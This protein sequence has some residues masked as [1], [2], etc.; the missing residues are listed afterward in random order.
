MQIT[1]FGKITRAFGAFLISVTIAILLA[2]SPGTAQEGAEDASAEDIAAQELVERAKTTIVTLEPLLESLATLESQAQDL[3]AQTEAASEAEQ[4]ALQE[5]LE[6]LGAEIDLVRDQISIVVTGVSEQEY[7]NLEST[8]F[9]LRRELEAL[10]EPFVSG[11]KGATENARQ[12]ERTRRALAATGRRLADAELAVENTEAAIPQASND[13]VLTLLTQ[14]LELWKER[15]E[16]NRSQY[17]ALTQQL[18]DLSSERAS[19]R[20]NVDSA[21]SGFFRDRGLSILLGLSAFTGFLVACR[22]IRW[23]AL[24]IYGFT[25]RPT[26]FAARLSNL[27]FTGFTVLG[28]FVAMIIVFNLRNDWLLLGLAGLLTFALLWLAIRMLPN[29]LEQITVLLNLGAVQEDER[30]LFNGV[31][32]RVSKLSFYTD[33]VNPALDGGEFTLPVRELVGLHSRPAAENE[34]WFP[35]EKGD[36]VRL[37]DGHAGQVVAQTPEMVVLKLLGGA[38]VT[39]QTSD[40]LDQTPENLSHGFRVE[41]EFGISY[42][43]QAKAATE[44]PRLM[45]DGVEAR[46]KAFLRDESLRAVEVEL[47]RAGTSSIDYEVEVDVGGAAAPRFEE[48]ERELARILVEL[49]TEND[50]EIPFQQVVVH[51]AVD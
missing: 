9:D 30:V 17:D 11:L 37:T 22:L 45:R 15:V 43:H 32:F 26:S 40:Y 41:V 10:V 13:T 29:L 25:G 28:S 12:I 27:I 46:I 39:Y 8:E 24:R 23:L 4:A 38:Q 47:L 21:L 14:Q 20:R 6:A 16:I 5:E 50:W 31:P 36:W 19:A 49:A 51:R 3:S 7:L 1:V 34:S 33:L 18:T 44:I 48:I 35:S 2:A 42:R